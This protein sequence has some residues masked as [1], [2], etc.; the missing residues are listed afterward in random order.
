MDSGSHREQERL[1]ICSCL[2]NYENFLYHKTTIVEI[3]KIIERSI[4]NTTIDKAK[5]KDIPNYWEEDSFIAQYSSIGHDIKIN[6]DPVSSIN[7]KQKEESK[8]YAIKCVNNYILS[9]LLLLLLV[10]QNGLLDEVGMYILPIIRKY[11]SVINPKNIAKL[12]PS[13]LNPKIN[14]PYIEHLKIRSEQTIKPTTSSLYVCRCG[15]KQTMI[16][17]LQ[18]R[19]LDE[20]GTVFAKC[21]NCGAVFKPRY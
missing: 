7:L 17:E 3:A 11:M 21:I 10:E 13:E 8:N 16:Y 9:K 2:T 18:T 19:S 12:S 1:E 6:L 14:E 5:E 15:C 4:Y 20:G